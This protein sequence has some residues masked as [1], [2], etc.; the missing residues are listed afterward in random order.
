MHCGAD[1]NF[2]KKKKEFWLCTLTSEEFSKFMKFYPSDLE[3]IYFQIDLI[4]QTFKNCELNLHGVF[5][6]L[7]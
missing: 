5:I 6:T 2:L 7:R 1:R 3:L 4:K